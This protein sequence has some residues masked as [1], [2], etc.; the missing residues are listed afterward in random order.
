MRRPHA[1]G[2]FARALGAAGGAAALMLSLASPAAAA[3]EWGVT[4]TPV[5]AYG[6]A[7]IAD[8]FV[9][10]S[11]IE[12]QSA[13]AEDSGYN[14]YKVVVTDTA[15]KD[16]K[17]AVAENAEV[18]VADELPEGLAV[19]ATGGGAGGSALNSLNHDSSLTR[20]DGWGCSVEL[21]TNAHLTS[22]TE[23]RPRKIECR[24]E[25]D[26]STLAE[27]ES[28]PTLYLGVSVESGL[29]TAP[30]TSA[31]LTDEATV[32]GG[33]ATASATGKSE[34]LIAPAV[35]FGLDESTPQAAETSLSVYDLAKEGK[36]TAKNYELEP[37][38]ATPATQA[39]GYPVSF[40]TQL[41]FNA[42]TSFSGR[43]T[44][45]DGSNDEFPLGPRSSSS[46]CR[47]DSSAIPST[48]ACA[49]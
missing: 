16:G 38:T 25:T 31:T 36:R 49:R 17:G 19:A 46:N 5:N 7:G 21:S 37:N 28:Y 47:R 44:A 34:T 9:T 8:P 11:L 45:P 35:P 33:G 39:G 6:I 10:G 24:R 23:Q 4:V 32:S 41:R 12:S 26:E 18:K 2:L 30:A 29:I 14:I 40:S 22:G 43:G 15:A 1:L 42:S 48:R 27:G 3:P 13:F 20:P